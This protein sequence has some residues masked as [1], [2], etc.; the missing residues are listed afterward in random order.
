MSIQGD[1]MSESTGKFTKFT[2]LLIKSVRV[3][4]T[5]TCVASAR[6]HTS[7]AYARYCH[8]VFFAQIRQKL[9]SSLPVR[10]DILLAV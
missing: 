1:P 2:V 3:T 9:T 6:S 4:Q 8:V 5:R 10:S 7:T